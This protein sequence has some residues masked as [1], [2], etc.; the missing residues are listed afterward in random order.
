MSAVPSIFGLL[1]AWVVAILP[2]LAAWIVLS[3]L[4]D[5]LIDLLW[6]RARR[7][8]KPDPPPLH[9]APPRIA[10]FVPCWREHRVI[11]HMVEHNVAA[12]RYPH[13]DFFIGVY[14]NDGP[15]LAAVRRLAARFPNV[16]L[17]VCAHDGPTSKADCLNWVFQRMLL[18][19]EE[20]DVRFGVVVT[21]DAEDLIHPHSLDAIAA[22]C[23]THGMVQVPVL[24]LPTPA[25]AWVHGIYI[26]E[27]TE[28]TL[29][30]MPARLHMGSFLPSSGV[31]TGFRR[32]VLEELA[33]RHGN[34]IFEPTCLTEDYENGLRV[35]ERGYAQLFV[36]PGPAGAE[37]VATREFFPQRF[38]A[39][40]RQRTRW[41]TGIALQG[42]QRRGWRGSWSTRYWFWRDRKGLVG[43][44]LSL[45]A[46]VLTAYGALTW[47]W[48]W[49]GGTAWGLAGVASAPRWQSLFAL[50]TALQ[51]VRLVSR[52]ARVHRFYGLPLA[53]G[54][55]VRAVV[56]NVING[57]ASVRALH[58]YAVARATGRPLVWLKTEH[59]YP[60]R[61]ALVAHKR[62]LGEVLV[63]LGFLS[64]EQRQQALA[65][66]P[67]GVLPGEHLCRLGWLNEDSLCVALSLQHGLPYEEQL[68][69][70][71]VPLP[72]ARSLPR[73]LL[74][75]CAVLPFRVEE[76]EL[77]VATPRVPS[78]EVHTRVQQHTRLTVRFHLVTPTLFARLRQHV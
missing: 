63:D 43:H 21:H 76:G 4:D 68:P 31:G 26:D 2:L 59:E 62:E 20:H 53:L 73:R 24:P 74:D 42:W 77:L 66:Q 47:A 15:T 3:G 78:D 41:V 12:I 40:V 14:P 75:D 28:F 36:S 60:N 69:V 18:F 39:A 71:A 10:I 11:A 9:S 1:D 55:P 44:P 50:V 34:R 58:R 64:E 54:T 17:A 7:A 37:C 48:A 67:A 29:R 13:Y 33:T 8:P 6:L 65:T 70:R 61:Q 57:L 51:T 38:R 19:E 23:R 22:G 25:T 16:Q 5:L 27:F 30:D 52:A 72:V 45:L 56:A 32:D 49:S 46:N 35:Y